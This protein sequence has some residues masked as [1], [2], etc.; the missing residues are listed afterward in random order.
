MLVPTLEVLRFLLDMSVVSPEGINWKTLCL[1]VQKAAYKTG[2]VRKLEACI[3]LYGGVVLQ[4][5]GEGRE[6]AKKRLGALMVHP[7]PRVRSAVVD[8]LWRVYSSGSNG[9]EEKG[10]KLLG[11]DWG[12]TNKGS[13]QQLVNELG[14][15]GA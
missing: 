8:Q 15:T 12:A 13:I 3:G 2:N 6:E 9:E 10:G 7:W 4:G 11:T 1:L 5:E 14:L